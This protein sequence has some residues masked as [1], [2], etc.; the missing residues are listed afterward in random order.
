M[1]PRV[2]HYLFERLSSDPL[3]SLTR[4]TYPKKSRQILDP[5]AV[6]LIIFSQRALSIFISS[7]SSASTANMRNWV[8]LMWT[9]ST[10]SLY[11]PVIVL[12]LAFAATVKLSHSLYR[13]KL[14][15]RSR[16]RSGTMS[17]TSSPSE[18][19][20]ESPRSSRIL[21]SKLY[22][23]VPCSKVN[24]YIN[25]SVLWILQLGIWT[26]S[27]IRCRWFTLQRMISHFSASRSCKRS[28]LTTF[29]FFE[30]DFDFDFF[31]M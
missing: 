9:D 15:R 12:V 4:S 26:I 8:I 17:F 27:P 21:S 3:V 29:L 10:R 30:F 2:L 1:E 11:K 7:N 14:R 16:T 20:N 5:A 23:D 25:S 28:N 22:F 13:Y 19:D 24:Q 6:G 31:Q 18:N